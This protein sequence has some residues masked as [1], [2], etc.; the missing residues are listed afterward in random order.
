M[1]FGRRRAAHRSRETNARDPFDHLADERRAAES[2]A[3][4]LQ[5]DD[6]PQL[7]VQAGVS[8]NLRDDDLDGTV[9]ATAIG[10]GGPATG[11]AHA[12]AD[13]DADVDADAR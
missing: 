5:P 10:A 6:A 2:E 13:V 1:P 7:D 8:S 4:F 9:G 12:D 11:D 3:W